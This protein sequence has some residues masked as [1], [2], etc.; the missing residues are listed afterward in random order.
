[1]RQHLSNPFVRFLL[2]GIPAYAAWYILYTYFIK[3]GVVDEFMVAQLT[4]TSTQILD[5]F[6]Y[7]ILPEDDPDIRTIGIDGGFYVWVGNEC[8]GLSLMALFSIFLMAFP[9]SWKHKSWY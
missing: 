9:G 3:D 8:D 6:G 1:M 2:I 7:S 4:D 5:W